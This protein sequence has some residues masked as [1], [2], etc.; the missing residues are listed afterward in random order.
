M[1]RSPLEVAVS[2]FLSEF[3]RSPSVF[4]GK[5]RRSSARRGPSGGL[6][7]RQRNQ[8]KT[9]SPLFANSTG[10]DLQ[11]VHRAREFIACQQPMENTAEDFW[12]MILQYESTAIVMLNRLEEVSKSYF[13]L[14]VD[15]TLEWK[16]L[17]V[18]TTHVAHR[19]SSQLEIRHLIVEKVGAASPRFL[20]SR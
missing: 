9:S 14:Q 8:G 16:N 11:G 1:R 4:R 13:P 10:I 3:L 2:S 20:Q 5:H 6:Y 15:Q 17:R 7:Q 12:Q 18:T 19:M